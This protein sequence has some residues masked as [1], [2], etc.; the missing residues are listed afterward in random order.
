MNILLHA[1]GLLLVGSSAGAFGALLGLGGGI[2]LVPLL[3][4]I[5]EL[6]MR[7]AVGASLVCVIATSCAA[8]SMNLTDGPANPRLG[9]ALEPA[10]VLGA[11]LGALAAP[12]LPAR[13][14]ALLFA[15]LLS[16]VTILLWRGREIAKEQTPL[17][18]SAQHATIFDAAYYDPRLKKEVSYTVERFPLCAAV[19]GLAGVFSALLGVGG[20]IIKVPAMN[21]LGRV[22]LKAAAA[23]STL[24]IG[25]TASTSAVLYLLRGDVPVFTAGTTALGVL[26]GSWMG[27]K[28]SHRIHDHALKRVFSAATFFFSLQMFW[29]ALR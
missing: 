10:T 8:S 27:L 3:V 6:P 5:F 7:S 1:A 13:A 12:L 28:L 29:K 25:A 20:G 11:L 26:A 18:S 4:L 17:K 16:Y 23:T 19:S 2:F 21:L 15:L 14:L 24:M 22:P 9:A